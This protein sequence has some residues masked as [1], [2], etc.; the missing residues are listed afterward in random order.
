M[1]AAPLVVLWALAPAVARW[2]SLP[3]PGAA[4]TL[5]LTAAERRTLRLIGRRTWRFFETFVVAG[6]NALP[7]DNVQ[8]DPRQVVAH[9]TSPT[10]VGLYLLTV[11]AARDHG[12]LGTLDAIDRLEATL[13]TVGRLVHFRGHLLNWYDTQSLEPLA[14]R[15]VSTVDSGNLAGHLLTLAEG[16]YRRGR[17]PALDRQ[18]LAGIADAVDCLREAAPASAGLRTQTVTRRHLDEALAAVETGLR[19]EGADLPPTPATAAAW[20]ERLDQLAASLHAVVDV[21]GALAHEQREGADA[22]AWGE[23]LAW[24]ELAAACV[25]SHRRDLDALAQAD[26]APA[27]APGAAGAVPG[28][29]LE[30]PLAAASPPSPG[31]PAAVVR[32]LEALAESALA[33]FAAM[34][35]GFL[36]DPVHKLFAIGYRADLGEL[37]GN[38]YD[39]L[40]SEARLA[41]FVAIAKGDVPVEHWF[42][43]G[44]QLTPVDRG[45]AL[46]SWSGSMFEYLM[47]A[48]VMRAPAHSLLDQTCRLVVRRQIQY[49]EE[50]GVPW[51]VSESAFNARDL[52]LTYQYSNFG[53]PG[54]GLKRGLSEDLVIAPYA[55]ALAAIFEPRA[56]IRNFARLAEAGAS[57]RFGFYEAVDYTA[58]RLP[59]EQNLAVVRAFMAHHQGMSLLAL[60]DV[61]DPC[62]DGALPAL[63]HAAPQVQATELLLQ[64]RTPRDVAVARPRAEEVAAAAQIGALLPPVERRYDSP[65]DTTP[66]SHLLGHGRYVVMLTAAGSGYSRAGDLAV[67]RYREDAT[68][69][70]WGTFFFLRDMHSG[71][72][73]SA[74]YQPSGVQADQYEAIFAEDR[75]EIVR[76]DGAIASRL[77]VVVTPEDEGEVRRLSLSNRG[78]R[79]S[80]IEVTSYAEVVLAPQAADAA[81]PAYSNL[82]VE[83]EFL[84]PTGALLAWRR[85]RAEGEARPWAVHVVAVDGDGAAGVQFET[86][87]ARFLGRGRGVRTPMSVVDGRPL[88][89]TAGA[90]L[91]PIFSLRRRVR[92]APGATVRV[93]FATLVAPS[94]EAAVALA[95]KYRDPAGFERAATMAWTQA[96]VHLRHLAIL[97]DEANL[98]QRLANRLLY[99]DVSLRA[100]AEVLQKNAAGAPALWALGISGDLPIVV[101]RIDELDDLGLVRQLLKAQEYFR[102]KRLAADLVI[103]NEKAPSYSQDLQ[104]ALEALLR[105]AQ[106]RHQQSDTQGPH[107]ETYLLR[108]EQID[109][110]ARGA[111]LAMARAVLVARRGSLAEQLAR[112]DRGDERR[113]VQ[114]SRRTTAAPADEPPPRPDLEF[115]NG[116]GGFRA[117]GRE[118]VT[119]LGEGQWTPAPWINVIANPGFGFQ[120]SESG[121]GYTWS[122]NSSQNQ[123]TPW[124]NDPVSDPPGEALYV[125]DEESGEVWGPTVLPIREESWLYI[126][127]HGQGYSR[128]EHTSHGIALDLL[129]L[130]PLADPVKI[131]RLTLTNRGTRP[132]RLSVTAYV[133]WVLGVSRSA[134]APSIVTEMDG[135]TGALLAR[136]A[137]N[138]E[139]GAGRVAFVDLA[140]RQTAWSGDRGEFLGRNGTLDHPAALEDREHRLSGRVG[141]GLDPAGVLQTVLELRPGEQAEVVCLLGECAGGEAARQLVERYR[142]ADVEEVLAEVVRYWDDVAGALQ[143]ETPDRSLDLLLNRWLL[144]QT[145]S[146]RVWARAAFYQAGGAYGFR[147]QLQDVMALT[148]ARREVARE[149]ILRAA[150]RQF[151]QGDVQHWWHPPSGR[152]VRTHIS[153]DLLWLPYTVLNYVEVTGEK[154]LFD[155][156]VAFL[157]GPPVPP[158]HDDAY[159]QPSV[160]EERA[161]LFEHCARAL[162]LRLAVGAHGLPLMG[163]GDWNDGMNRVG[164]QGKGESVWLGWFLHT[165]LWEYAALADQRGESARADAWRQHRAALKEALERAW[166]GDWYRRGYFDDG[167]PLGSASGAECKIDS[168]AQSWAVIS[169]A[170]LRDRAVRAMAAVEEYL[171]HRGDGLVLLFTPPFDSSALDPGYIKGYLPGVRENGGQYTHAAI[172]C[173]L[174]FAAL[175]DGDRAGELMSILNPINHASTRAGI[176]RYKVE[177]YVAAADIYAQ[178]HHVGRGGWTWYSGSAGWMYRAGVE[179]ILG[180]RMRG[181]VLSIDPSIPRAWPRYQ[182]T[183]RYHSATYHLHVDNPRGATRGVTAAEMDGA[184]L[185]VLPHGAADVALVKDGTHQIRIVLG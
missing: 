95:E 120:V 161:S 112:R 169:G 104:A 71:A 101:A 79:P 2:L 90:V 85:P 135:A 102:S 57:G 94:R 47:P 129:Q 17:L 164:R 59:E 97:P 44:R 121:A 55:T 5:P 130:V 36:Y 150:A 70:C 40:A 155:Q 162:D 180:V 48:L 91:D 11:V 69:D 144:Y 6:D 31:L 105:T 26:P 100:P 173:V 110:T 50:R 60:A 125:R 24:A 152:G 49:G 12:W 9:R 176:Q 116:L 136:R 63:F 143:V 46:I 28:E 132:R 37:D 33:A 119:I 118:Y 45:A 122:V 62:D 22:A 61:L 179:W 142:K 14:P 131:S 92:L 184:A 166:D 134:S 114:R 81:H 67:T 128:F 38:E 7:P 98:F 156:Q 89:N 73:W 80:E 8:E 140:G 65:H 43:L 41:S 124:S 15:Y 86:D 113:L 20:A 34:E 149:Q 103:V 174:A 172:W 25:A 126:A 109:A 16:C 107:G 160:T 76:R 75:A 10:N 159:F 145:L 141:A 87:R 35:F 163:T 138:E 171:V 13:A 18:V 32:R 30:V 23:V 178:S 133:E 21:A 151:V 78:A 117:D 137:W 148:R 111:L 88:S 158:D 54:L 170:A 99:S 106:A 127:R 167:T 96:Q 42:H 4:E 39:L 56:A 83:T 157:D 51:G 77:E 64:E 68:R 181:T 93:V 139:L 58:S 74:G 108:N 154:E 27:A 168:I 185:P 153:D 147:D 123:L 84:A 82:F 146:C 19:S 66:R 3:L 72:V 52:Q 115:W 165:L 53:V 182:V 29:P 177:P 175:G 1:W 183:F